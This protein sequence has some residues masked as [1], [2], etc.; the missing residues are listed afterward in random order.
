[1]KVHDNIEFAGTLESFSFTKGDTGGA[2]FGVYRDKDGNTVMEADVI[3]GRIGSRFKST[4][5]HEVEHMGGGFI[6]SCAGIKINAVSS[7]EDRIRCHFDTKGGSKTNKFIE[8]DG[9]FCQRFAESG[10]K[11]YW[12]RVIGVGDD[13]V[14][15]SLEDRDDGDYLPEIDDSLIQLGHIS[16]RSRQNAICISTE[17]DDAPSLIVYGGIDGFSLSGKDLGGCKFDIN[18]E[19]IVYFGYGSMFF[20]DRSGGN[21]ISFDKTTGRLDISA[22]VTIGKGSSGLENLSEWGEKQKQIDQAKGFADALNSDTTFTEVEKREIRRLMNEITECTGPR[23]TEYNAKVERSTTSGNEWYLVNE[24][25]V[26][27]YY[28]DE[29]DSIYSESQRE[30]AGFYSSDMHTHGSATVTRLTLTVNKAF[31]LKLEF[32]S[33]S[34][35]NYDFL[36]VGYPNTDVDPDTGADQQLVLASTCFASDG[37]RM[38]ETIEF[39]GSSTSDYIEISYRKDGSVCIGTD[40]GYYRLLNQSY[41]GSDGNEYITEM[42]GSFHAHYLSLMRNGHVAEAEKLTARLND[43]MSYL[44]M[45]ELWGSGSSSIPEGFRTQLSS[46][47]SAYQACAAEVAQV[48]AN[49]KS[50]TFVIQPAPPYKAGDLW[51]QGDG[52]EIMR[53]KDGIDRTSGSYTA[54][55]WELAS[56]YTDDTKAKEALAVANTAQETANHAK[57]FADALNSDTIFTEVE[58]R[59]IRRLLSE[60]TECSGA[61]VTEYNAKVERST[62]QGDEW[63]LVNDNS[64]AEWYYEDYDED[65]KL[66]QSAW[67]GYY[68]SNMHTNESET[69]IR[70]SLTILKPFDLKIKFGSDAEG[71]YD[72]LNVGP[73]DTPVDPYSTEHDLEASAYQASTYGRQGID[74]VMTKN[75]AIDGTSSSHFIELSYM[76]DSSESYNTDSGY[77][78][79]MNDSYMGTDGNEYIVEMNGSF[80]KYY[81]TLM[82]NG[83]TAEATELKTRLNAL[84]SFLDENGLWASENTTVDT[85][86]RATLN[87]YVAKYYAYAAEIGFGVSMDRI[88]D[89][90]YLTNAMKN[91][92]TII[93]GGLVMSSMVAVA[94]TENTT[95]ADVKAFLNGG[96]FAKD[97]SEDGHGKLIIAGGIPEGAT[98]LEARAKTAKTRI[99]EDGHVETNDIVATGGAFENVVVKGSTRSPFNSGVQFTI[100]EK[101]NYVNIS[102]SEVFTQLSNN[103]SESGRRLTFVGRFGIMCQNGYIYDHGTAYYNEYMHIGD[104]WDETNPVQYEV[105]TLIAVKT[106]S[107]TVAWVVENREPWGETN[108]SAV[109][110]SGMFAG[111]RPNIREITV[112]S[113]SDKLTLTQYDHTV[114]VNRA[115]ESIT[116]KAPSSPQYGQVYKIFVPHYNTSLTISNL[117]SGSY[118]LISGAELGGSASLPTGYRLEVDLFYHRHWW[119]NYR[120]LY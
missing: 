51:V 59:E 67:V 94:D 68:S 57:D 115:G 38:T 13:Y 15:L 53:C 56:K 35:E 9:G 83:Y 107:T 62:E 28:D 34:E 36:N 119:L 2:G 77:Y 98:D 44:D 17:G 86:F 78:R 58:K 102:T 100:Q 111:L 112:S 114:I 90:E 25:S 52:G 33:D 23:V 71:N 108:Y 7:F 79:L 42:Q 37:K 41:M 109:K 113:P 92:K 105:L 93:N 106:S 6:Y 10:Y 31:Y 70:L 69:I 72:F 21:S 24:D 64:Y 84:M 5:I 18:K 91:G 89:T 97:T 48:T 120:Y 82:R 43:L 73:L 66:S 50:K 4:E 27:E 76:K 49:S 8:G 1:M 117:G 81:L 12:M 118:N 85:S 30:W 65:V 88:N 54:S 16:E 32:A 99:Y 39:D 29:S 3:V 95:D 110:P 40:S 63:Y 104:I 26:V 80:H 55:D 11:I 22:N 20:G 47:I 87:D 61:S 14:D 45:Y 19:E 74:N 75:F 103:I 60:I 96:D 116:L 46:L 101:D